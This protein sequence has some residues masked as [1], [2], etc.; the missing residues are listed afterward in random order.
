MGY[1]GENLGTHWQLSTD[2][3]R[4]LSEGGLFQQQ[5]VIEMTSLQPIIALFA[6]LVVKKIAGKYPQTN[7]R[8]QSYV[9]LTLCIYL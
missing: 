3:S 5:S 7:E 6:I 9:T 1:E 4:I 2:S 8:C